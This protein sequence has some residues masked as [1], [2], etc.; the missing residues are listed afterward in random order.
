MVNEHTKHRKVLSRTFE[1]AILHH[2][3]LIFAEP[4]FALPHGVCE[5]LSPAMLLKRHAYVVERLVLLGATHM[6]TKYCKAATE[7][8]S[9]FLRRAMV[10]MKKSR[11]S[12]GV[13][14]R[15]RAV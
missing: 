2:L 9:M 15:L 13:R 8:L 3:T 10:M 4:E 11:R 5:V 12:L 6:L 1:V 7:G 14:A